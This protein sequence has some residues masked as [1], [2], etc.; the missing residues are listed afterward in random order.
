MAL[1]VRKN[2]AGSR[3]ELHVDGDLVGVAD[4][5]VDGDRVVIPHTEIDPRRRGQGLA[6]V[7]VREALDDLR[8]SGQ[9]VVPTCWY[10][11]QYIQEHPE[12]HDLLGN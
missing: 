9:T 3:Y 5:A 2:E 6:A 7:L 1:E 10:V 4:Y 8:A 12:Y 11:A